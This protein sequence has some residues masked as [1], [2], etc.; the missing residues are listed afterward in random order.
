MASTAILIGN[1]EYSYQTTLACCRDDLAAM[2]QLLEATQKYDV[3][4]VIENADADSLKKQLRDA[5]DRV[6]S[7]TELFFY[8]TGHGHGLE[9]ELYYCATDFI[10]TQPNQT[11]LSTSELHTI[12]RSANA[13][14]VVKVIDACQS[15]TRLI[16]DTASYFAMPK[17]DFQDILQIASSLETQNS[18]TGDPLSVFTAKFREAALRKTEGAVLYTD[19]INVLRDAFI[20]DEDQTPHFIVQGTGR[21]QFVDDAK[22]LDAL[23]QTLDAARE[24]AAPPPAVPAVVERAPLSLLDR[25]HAA[26]K[27][28]VTPKLMSQFIGTFFDQLQARISTDEFAEF[29]ELE[30]VEHARFAESTTEQFIIRVLT[31]ERRADNFVT[32]HYERKLRNNFLLGAAWDL[33][34]SGIHDEEWDLRLNCT[35]ERTQLKITFTPK[36]ANLQRVTLVVTCA[37]SLDFCYIFEFATQHMLRDFGVYESAGPEIARRWWKRNWAEGT[38]SIVDEISKKLEEVVRLQ[39]ESAE[40]RLSG[41]TGADS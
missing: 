32:A 41:E 36:F 8:F 16:K 14:L 20:G 25:L 28:V 39:L 10:A 38:G 35:M 11:G 40:K 34:K 26:E 17:S 6:L 12:L 3:I 29:F 22:K 13:A 19:I 31:K 9:G 24:A 5:V 23:R 15:G 30:K 33:L 2:K 1:S 21:Q 4:C 18:S 7:P 37:P 27:K